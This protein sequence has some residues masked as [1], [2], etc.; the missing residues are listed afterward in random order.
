VDERVIGGMRVEGFS[1][2][3]EVSNRAREIASKI[4]GKIT[5]AKRL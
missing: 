2:F 3:Y 1:V 4:A 5:I